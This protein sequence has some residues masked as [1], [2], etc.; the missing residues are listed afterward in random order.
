MGMAIRWQMNTV[1]PIAKG[2]STCSQTQHQMKQL[3]HGTQQSMRRALVGQI[4]Q[5]LRCQGVL[6]AVPCPHRQVRTHS[7]ALGVGCTEDDEDQ[8]LQ[9]NVRRQSH[10]MP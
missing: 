4:G 7:T 1:K 3:N 8:D 6:A 9:G 2:A 10:R 5:L